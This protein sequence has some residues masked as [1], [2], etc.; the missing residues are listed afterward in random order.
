M[1]WCYNITNW[2]SGTYNFVIILQFK[3]I[4]LIRDPIT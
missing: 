3:V 4:H 1:V 2:W